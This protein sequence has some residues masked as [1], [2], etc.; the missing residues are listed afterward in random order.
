MKTLPAWAT[1][2]A[3]ARPLVSGVSCANLHIIFIYAFAHEHIAHFD[4]AP[5]STS[6]AQSDMSRQWQE[7]P[8]FSDQD[9]FGQSF[10]LHLSLQST[11]DKRPPLCDCVRSFEKLGCWHVCLSPPS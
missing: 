3:P 2:H 9:Y 5:Y 1:A 4:T 6:G 10:Q 7:A 11:K 8:G